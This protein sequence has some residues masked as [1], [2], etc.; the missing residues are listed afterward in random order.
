MFYSLVS[1]CAGGEQRQEKWGQRVLV[2]AAFCPSAGST[3][4]QH[5]LHWCLLSVS[6]LDV[7][8]CA[9]TWHWPRV[10]KTHS[11]LTLI[12]LNSQMRCLRFSIL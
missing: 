12:T 8:N 5:L 6:G 4:S 10:K 7:T 3:R 1:G 2:R 9:F 11:I